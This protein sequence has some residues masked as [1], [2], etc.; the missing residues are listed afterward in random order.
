M[1][2]K[3]IEFILSLFGI[4]L[5]HEERAKEATIYEIKPF[6]S[7][8]ER[9]FYNILKT[10]EN[11]HTI[12][13]QLNLASIIKKKNNNRYYTE[14]FR[15]IDFAIFDKDM[16]KLLLLI[17]INDSTHKKYKRKDRDLK[18]KKICNDVNIKLLT[19]YTNYPNEKDYVLNRIKK[20]LQH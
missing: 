3:I 14:L 20:V 4:S 18:V 9:K 15:N 12:I 7:Q 19:F 1:V 13:P 16:N 10:L 11:E 2:K 6:M 17:E 5:L 8:Y